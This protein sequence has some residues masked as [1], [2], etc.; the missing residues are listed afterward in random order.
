MAKNTARK[1]FFNVAH[2]RASNCSTPFLSLGDTFLSRMVL[3]VPVLMSF[4]DERIVGIL[5]NYIKD[6]QD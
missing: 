6:S 2:V 4:H 1:D 5:S 3:L